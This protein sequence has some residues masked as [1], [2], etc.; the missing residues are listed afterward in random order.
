M[1]LNPRTVYLT[2]TT[3]AIS[4]FTAPSF[5]GTTIGT[6]AQPPQ[7]ST[8]TSTARTESTQVSATTTGLY[9]Y[10]IY[11]CSATTT[12]TTTNSGYET[13]TTVT[14]T[15][16][17]SS[18]YT[19]ISGYL[20]SNGKFIVEFPNAEGAES[21]SVTL[22]NLPSSYATYTGPLTVVGYW[23]PQPPIMF[24]NGPG[25]TCPMVYTFYVVTVL[26]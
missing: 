25:G 24:C 18:I 26:P 12:W 7:F 16:V 22:H 14:E 3:T 21:I 10:Y 6:S 13:S 4:S 20:E 1:T 9:C 15:G 19:T 17:P 11:Q 5:V 2:E 8:L 23:G